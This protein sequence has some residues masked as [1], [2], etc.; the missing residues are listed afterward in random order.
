MATVRRRA[1]QLAARCGAYQR[2]QRASLALE[3]T[4]LSPSPPTSRWVL[5]TRHGHR[6]PAKAVEMDI[7]CEAERWEALL[8][9]EEEVTDFQTRFSVTNHN[10]RRPMD[11]RTKPFGC[12]TRKG[13]DY[14]TL[15]GKE[16]A[17]Q[18]P[19]VQDLSVSVTST[20]FMRT[21]VN[22]P[23]DFHGR[24]HMLPAVKH[25]SL[26]KHLFARPE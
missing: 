25:P 24:V 2:Q 10:T 23:P 16:M 20:N 14:M 8:P 12:L 9:S 5:F 19:G 18:I 6:A 17:S 13:V 22:L 26:P 11:S 21:Q 15:A 7:Q 3:A 4:E 1:R